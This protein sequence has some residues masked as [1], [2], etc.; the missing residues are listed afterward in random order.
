MT[1]GEKSARQTD[2]Q[3]KLERVSHHSRYPV[4]PDNDSTVPCQDKLYRRCI[5]KIW[6]YRLEAVFLNLPLRKEG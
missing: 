2:E 5:P 4:Y 6:G 1:H 3:T